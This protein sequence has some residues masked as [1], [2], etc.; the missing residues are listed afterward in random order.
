[1]GKDGGVE[2]LI[3]GESGLGMFQVLLRNP[4][5]FFSQISFPSDQEEAGGWS[6]TVVY[7]FFNFVFFFPLDK[8]QWWCGEVLALDFI[9][10]VRSEKGGV[11]HVMDFPGLGKS[12]LV[13][14][15][16]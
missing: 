14:D 1:M 6:S 11:E 15:R 10:S 5:V 13:N 2:F 12:E 8:F 7:D 4:G 16:R 9:L 3:R